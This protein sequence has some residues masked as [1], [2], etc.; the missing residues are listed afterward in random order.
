MLNNQEN[1]ESLMEDFRR[2]D[3]EAFRAI[4]KQFYPTLCYFAHSLIGDN[5]NVEVIVSEAFRSLWGQCEQFESLNK[6]RSFIY[7]ATATNCLTYL[8]ALPH[9]DQD[10]SDL[11]NKLKNGKE[12]YVTIEIIRTEIFRQIREEIEALSA[13]EKNIY[14]LLYIEGMTPEQIAE[15]LN[16]PFENVKEIC[17]RRFKK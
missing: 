11:L 15:K 6:I 17:G 3:H 5:E 16:L 14:K 10:K 4:F 8:E 7:Q 13:E 9:P 12:E 2:G 1:E